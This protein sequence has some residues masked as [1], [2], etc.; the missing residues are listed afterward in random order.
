MKVHTVNEKGTDFLYSINLV[1]NK[2]AA[3]DA[4][5]FLVDEYGHNNTLVHRW[6][7]IWS[8]STGHTLTLTD[9]YTWA[10]QYSRLHTSTNTNTYTHT[11]TRTHHL[12]TRTHTHT[13]LGA[14]EPSCGSYPS[15]NG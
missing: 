6:S 11:E 4:N 7:C 14:A 9:T 10:I 2:A 8:L 12:D 5:E 3:N 13:Y 1:D 15:F